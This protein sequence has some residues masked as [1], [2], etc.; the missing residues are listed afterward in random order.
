[1]KLQYREFSLTIKDPRMKIKS[2]SQLQIL[3]DLAQEQAATLEKRP[4]NKAAAQRLRKT[5]LDITKVG[6]E[7]RKESIEA[8]K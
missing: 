2:L 1:M 8:S 6:K 3:L 4:D 5:T 7:F